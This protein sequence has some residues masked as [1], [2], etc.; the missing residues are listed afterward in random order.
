VPFKIAETVKNAVTGQFW[1]LF[2]EEFRKFFCSPNIVRIP[3]GRR[4]RMTGYAGRQK[5]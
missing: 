5:I 1:V 4:I 2:V 3:Q